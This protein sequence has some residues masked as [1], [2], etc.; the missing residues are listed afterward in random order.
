MNAALLRQS[1]NMVD[2]DRYRFTHL[3]YVRLFQY[4]PSVRALFPLDMQKQEQKLADT[5]AVVISAVEGNDPSL[6]DTLHMLGRKH[7][8][9]GAQPAH[10]P[11]VAKVLLET[12]ASDLGP[13][14]TPEMQDAWTEALTVVA[15]KMLEGA[16]QA[17]P[18]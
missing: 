14:F 9:L 17:L 10:Y 3:F 12:F 7:Q 4:Y 16:G 15:S 8:E 2:A 1:W 5:L 18:V 13:D 11:I 6:V